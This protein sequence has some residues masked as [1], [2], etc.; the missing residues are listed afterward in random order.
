[1]P[2]RVFYEKKGENVTKNKL[3]KNITP[4]LEIKMCNNNNSIRSFS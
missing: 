1:M 4:T 3:V 2:I